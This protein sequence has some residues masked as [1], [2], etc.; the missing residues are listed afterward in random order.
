MSRGAEPEWADRASVAF[1]VD[2]A[3]ELRGLELRLADEGRLSIP[4]PGKGLP[5]E[6][7]DP[8]L[9]P[10]LP[11]ETR[12]DD[13]TLVDQHPT[14]PVP[15]VLSDPTVKGDCQELH[16]TLPYE[17]LRILRPRPVADPQ[18]DL[19]DVSRPTVVGKRQARMRSSD[20]Q[21]LESHRTQDGWAPGAGPAEDSLDEVATLVARVL[22]RDLA[23]GGALTLKR[24]DTGDGIVPPD[25]LVRVERTNLLDS[26]IRAR[27][28]QALRDALHP[29]HIRAHCDAQTMIL[30]RS[31][32]ARRADERA[33][34]LLDSLPT[35]HWDPESQ[36][37]CE[38]QR[39]GFTVLSAGWF[40]EGR[41]AERRL[42]ACAEGHGPMPTLYA[43]A[44]SEP[45]Q[46]PPRRAVSARLLLAAIFVAFCLFPSSM[47]AA[48][49]YPV[50][51]TVSA[52]KAAARRAVGVVR[53]LFEP[54]EGTAEARSLQWIPPPASGSGP[55]P[56]D[57]GCCVDA[58]GLATRIAP[59]LP[60][61]VPTPVAS[62]TT[63]VSVELTSV[64][65]I[66]HFDDL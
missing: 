9:P 48:R 52:V 54:P 57:A 6:G 47:D 34:C 37:Q 8:Q 10:R 21:R 23:P 5:I 24:L 15:A 42:V 25:M 51:R 39:A 12:P 16:E 1:L 29:D 26:A 41:A 60:L 4:L 11:D 64:Q 45:D 38:E 40:A 28:E 58:A 22:E 53:G 3:F 66:A 65:P 13:P 62:E 55:T 20:A 35:T 18:S 59:P 46:N 31:R 32:L 7:D 50:E 33:V 43:K 63:P 17:R 49:A 56:P 19:F 36:L 61:A 44:L 14:R 27:V 2:E 30:V